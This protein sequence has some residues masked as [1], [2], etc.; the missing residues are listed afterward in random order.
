MSFQNSMY[1]RKFF[2]VQIPE[3]IKELK[4]I[5]NTLENQNNN[6]EHT[7]LIAATMTRDIQIFTGREQDYD[8]EGDNEKYWRD[9]YGEVILGSV[10]AKD[11]FEALEKGSKEFNISK[12]SIRA[13]QIKE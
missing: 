5:A 9:C 7:Y 11:F 2:D 13:Y 12:D 6:T 4:R 1:A 3:I 10:L 8:C